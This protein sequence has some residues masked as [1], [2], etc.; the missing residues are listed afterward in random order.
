MN[1]YA[2]MDCLFNRVN[3]FYKNRVLGYDRKQ[4]EV[5]MMQ[6]MKRI[7]RPAYMAFLKRWRDQP[8]VKVL[9]GIRRA[10]KSTLFDMYCE[11]LVTSGVAPAQIIQINFEDLRFAG[12]HDYM[13][14]YAY[15][16][17]RITGDQMHYVFLDEV[18]HITAFERLVDHL[19]IQP[20]V[21]LYITGSNAYFMSGELATMIAGR[22]VELHM[23]PLSFREYVS[24]RRMLAPANVPA[25][26][27]L[28]QD[29]LHF[30]SFP[31]TVFLHQNEQ[32]VTEYLDGLY[33]SIVL[34]DIVARLKVADELML[35]SI[36]R[37]VFNNVGNV[38]S[39]RKVA[40]AMTAAGRKI[41]PVTV[42]KYLAGLRDSLL[43][44]QAHRYNIK[45]KQHLV[46]NDKYYVADLGLRTFLLGNSE[47]DYGHMLENVVYLELLRRGYRVF[48]GNLPHDEIDFVAQKDGKTAYYQVAASVLDPHTLQRELRP[49]SQINDQYPKYLLT[50]DEFGNTDHQGIQQLNALRWLMKEPA[51]PEAGT[52]VL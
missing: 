9:S 24:G 11:E 34:K 42:E 7:A 50:L 38:L 15:L 48:V 22:Y 5:M 4:R 36:I 10:G 1:I 49:F 30:S 32:L 52:N 40:G 37:F 51:P 6:Q 20:N 45:G 17:P 29:Y 13:D 2:K 46:T 27:A 41:S 18:Q 16:K 44:Y 43:V 23:L 47:V 25:L 3:K 39:A 28:Y 21:D 33:S 19:V 35:E 12:M 26:S 14:V 8:V 31:Y